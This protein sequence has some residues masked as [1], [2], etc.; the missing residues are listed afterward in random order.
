MRQQIHQLGSYTIIDDSYNASPEATKVSID[1]LKSVSK[2]QS[3][4]VLADMLELGQQSAQ[5]HRS[6]GEHL[7]KTGIDCLIA[8][9]SQS[10][11]TAQGAKDQGCKNVIT[12]DNNDEAYKKLKELLTDGCTVLVKGSR[13]MHTDEIVKKLIA[14][15]SA[16]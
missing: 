11:N 8:I 1:V 4:A 13:G 14:D 6:V 15:Y 9:G 10:E 7:A 12:A 5:L 16:G 3:I 2:N